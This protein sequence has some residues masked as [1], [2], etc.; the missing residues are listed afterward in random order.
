MRFAMQQFCRAGCK[1]LLWIWFFRL[2]RD[3]IVHLPLDPGWHHL[4]RHRFVFVLVLCLFTSCSNFL[5]RND[6]FPLYPL[7]EDCCSLACNP[8]AIPT[9]F[10]GLHTSSSFVV[11]LF[12][13]V[14]VLC[15]CCCFCCCLRF[16]W[17]FVCLC[18]GCLSVPFVCCL[19]LW[20]IL[21]FSQALARS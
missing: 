12:V 6:C 11:C 1:Y 14:F 8:T 4:G 20:A 7:L 15:V 10:R 18:F 21:P 17:R 5:F 9:V 19:V 13:A 3:P 16:V 2:S